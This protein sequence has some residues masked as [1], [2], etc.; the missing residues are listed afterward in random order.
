ML[1]GGRF[2]S[3]V[4]VLEGVERGKGV[5]QGPTAGASILLFGL[6]LLLLSGLVIGFWAVLGS[7]ELCGSGVDFLPGN[8]V[9]S[10]CCKNKNQWLSVAVKCGKD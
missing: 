5:K 4:Q 7:I 2:F 9:F 6:L 1:F 8:R 10:S 3:Q